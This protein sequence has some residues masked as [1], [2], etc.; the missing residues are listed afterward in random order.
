MGAMQRQTT[1]RVV[2]ALFLTATAAGIISAVL[3]EPDSIG[4]SAYKAPAGAL[5]VLV[6]SVA[7]A[8]IPPTLFP[9]IKQFGEASALAY[10]VARTVEVVLLLPATIGPLMTL[11]PG[12]AH[13]DAARTVTQIY[14]LWGYTGSQVFFC[15]GAALLNALL[16]RSRLVPRWISGWALVAV[17]PYLADAVLV[18]FDVLDVSS[19]IHATLVV[20][21]AVNEMVLAIWLLAKGLA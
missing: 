13:A 1:A 7:I 14:D 12:S 21:M 4:D 6:M 8:L 17:V 3:L 5:M 20:P 19:P 9:V 10:I 2:G 18:M 16:F 11:A 15:L